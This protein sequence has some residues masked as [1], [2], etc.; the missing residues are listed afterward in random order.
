MK[1]N[2]SSLTSLVS[3]FGRAYHSQND[4]PKIFDDLLAIDLI[5]PKEFS[6]IREN[7]IRGMPFFNPDMAQRLQ[8]DPDE[9]L[10][11]IV[12][13]QL[14]PTPLARAAYCE[15]VLLHEMKLGLKQYV[16]LGAGLDT[17]GFRHP[18]LKNSLDI[19]EVDHP[20]TQEWKKQRLEHARFDISS[21]LHF[22]PMDFTRQFSYQNLFDEGFENHK[23]FFSL[24]GVSY[25]LTKEE[26]SSLIHHLFAKVPAGSSIVLDYADENLFVEKG[27][28]NRVQNM[29]KMAAAS[30]E[31]M[32]SCFS[33]DEIE[34]LLEQSG[35]LIYEHL[36]PAAIHDQ[37]FRRR[38]DYLSAFETIHYIHA[39]KK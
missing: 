35:L 19:F 6:D 33:Y 10:K 29:V 22:V 23:T 16:I 7:M 36:S 11:W 39:V 18:E 27:T 12:Q 25:Y 32:K 38:T 34:K 3:A 13:V 1:P 21:H 14:S 4:T 5:T 8:D 28:S 30:G 9:M 15:K 20:A 31:P 17:F 37:F 24:L 26:I 2:E